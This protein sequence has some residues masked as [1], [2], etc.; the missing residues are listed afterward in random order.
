MRGS[1]FENKTVIKA[2]NVTYGETSGD[3]LGWSVDMAGKINSDGY[4][5]IITGAPHFDNSTQVDAGKA[6]I[7]SYDVQSVIPEFSTMMI[8]ILFILI[9]IAI[10]RRSKY[11]GIKKWGVIE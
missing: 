11:L 7:M 3:H 10:A 8:P 5:E 2:E 9:I 4:K 1:S 6:Y